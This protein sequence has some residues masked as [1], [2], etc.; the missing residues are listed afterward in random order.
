MAIM[1]IAIVL[2]GVAIWNIKTWSGESSKGKNTRRAGITGLICMGIVVILFTFFV[3]INDTNTIDIENKT[4]YLDYARPVS[5]ISVN[6]EEM[7]YVYKCEINDSDKDVYIF[8][9]K[10]ENNESE[11]IATTKVTITQSEASAYK[12]I[13]NSTIKEY[14]VE[15]T[16]ILVW[17]G[18][19]EAD[20]EPWVE[21]SYEIFL[22]S[23][24]H[25]IEIN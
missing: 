10:N 5:G 17:L 21:K 1:V 25:V 4:F 8:W 13:E 11:M 14:K 18:A 19:F 7:P 6:V 15:R 20:E 3:I 16:P 12:I 22:P 9:V 23:K 24:T 2:F